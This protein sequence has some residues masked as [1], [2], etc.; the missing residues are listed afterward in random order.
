MLPVTT[1]GFTNDGTDKIGGTLPPAPQQA[2]LHDKTNDELCDEAAD[3]A[4][5][6]A[7][8]G[9]KDDKDIEDDI[10]EAGALRDMAYK[11]LTHRVNG[12]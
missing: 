2:N 11:V 9:K 1:R 10:P 12:A 5:G 6:I 3:I 7:A 8:G 4:P